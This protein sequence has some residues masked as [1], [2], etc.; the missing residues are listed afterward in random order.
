MAPSSDMPVAEMPRMV[1][2]WKFAS[3]A[4]L[5]TCFRHSAGAS[6]IQSAV[7]VSLFHQLMRRVNVQRRVRFLIW[8]TTTFDFT[9]RTTPVIVSPAK[10]FFLTSVGKERYG[11]SSNQAWYRGLPQG[12][13][14]A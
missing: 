6:T 1:T 5:Q 2:E 14:S 9:I 10:T 8:S 11:T 13:Q 4:S 12:V 3:D 7:D